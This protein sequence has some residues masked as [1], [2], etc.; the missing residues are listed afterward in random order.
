LRGSQAKVHH[1]GTIDG[2]TFN[3]VEEE[4]EKPIIQKSYIES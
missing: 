1:F 2:Q 3:I 4:F